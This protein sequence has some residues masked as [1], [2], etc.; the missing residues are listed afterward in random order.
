MKTRLVLMS[1]ALCAGLALAGSRTVMSRYQLDPTNGQPTAATVGIPTI[2]ESLPLKSIAVTVADFSDGGPTDYE[3]PRHVETRAWLY[4]PEAAFPDGGGK[5]SR[6][7]Q[8]DVYLDAGAVLTHSITQAI[9]L[10]PGLLIPG[11]RIYF[12]TA[13]MTDQ[14]A[15]SRYHSVIIEGRY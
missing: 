15:G 13:G 7:P 2:N 3:Y 10:T 11:E 12:S 4:R 6:A 14:D 9:T 1:L 5:W 8:F